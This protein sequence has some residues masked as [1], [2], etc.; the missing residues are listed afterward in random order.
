MSYKKLLSGDRKSF[1]RE[2]YN[3]MD[4]NAMANTHGR[5]SKKV[6]FLQLVEGNEELSENEKR[7]CREKY[8]YKFELHNAVYK[9]GEPR[10]VTNVKQQD[11]PINI[12]KGV[13]V[14]I[15]RAF[16]I[17]GHLVMK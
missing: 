14:Y 12:V 6:Y 11:I 9:L 16:L 8:I 17:L 13:L 5:E 3:E 15:Y 2:V 10:N 7:Y 4:D 1:V